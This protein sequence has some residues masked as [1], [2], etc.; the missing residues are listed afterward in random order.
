MGLCA[1][2]VLR[3]LMVRAALGAGRALAF[4][5]SE[6]R[7][8]RSGGPVGTGAV[9]AATARRR[10]ACPS[11]GGPMKDGNAAISKPPVGGQGKEMRGRS[12]GVPLR[13]RGLEGSGHMSRAKGERREA[14]CRGAGREGGLSMRT[15]CGLLQAVAGPAG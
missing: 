15:D 4:E 13:G 7:G 9:R 5:K 10:G 12:C 3:G 6:G 11:D 14:Q 2:L 8:R 1:G